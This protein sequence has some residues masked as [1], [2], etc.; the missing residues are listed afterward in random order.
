M[1]NDYQMLP[2]PAID[3][4]ALVMPWVEMVTGGALI[5]GV[6]LRHG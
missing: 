6:W 1:L 5:L 4:V 2:L 3:A